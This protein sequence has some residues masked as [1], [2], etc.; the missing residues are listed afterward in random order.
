MFRLQTSQDTTVEASATSALGW[1]ILRQ[2]GVL[3]L[4][5]NESKPLALTITVPNDA[6]AGANETI[7]LNVANE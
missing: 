7:T 1:E 5:A 2:P 3:E 4:T 6:T